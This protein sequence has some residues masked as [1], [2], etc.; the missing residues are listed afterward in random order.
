MTFTGD[1]Q[2]YTCACSSQGYITFLALC[3]NILRRDLD[4][5]DNVKK[6]MLV[7]DLDDIMLIESGEQKIKYTGEKPEVGF[8]SRR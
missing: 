1:Q 6:F 2:Q 8:V 5:L 7:H 3:L 4:H